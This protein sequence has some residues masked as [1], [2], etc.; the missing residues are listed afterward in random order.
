MLSNSWCS[1]RGYYKIL[2][3]EFSEIKL[4]IKP[5]AVQVTKMRVTG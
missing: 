2:K 4:H 5:Q 1:N 3:E